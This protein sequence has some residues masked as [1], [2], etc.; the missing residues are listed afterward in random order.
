MVI[1][2]GVKT[3]SIGLV[4]LF[5]PNKLIKN[6]D[7]K[8]PLKQRGEGE[9]GDTPSS[10]DPQRSST[11]KPRLKQLRELAKASFSKEEIGVSEDPSSSQTNWSG[12][13][14]GKRSGSST[15][16][17]SSDS[18]TKPKG[19]YKDLEAIFASK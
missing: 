1:Y 8:F 15:M 7:S 18:K 11:E 13:W 6:L 14:T 10:G 19:L 5:L 9:T 3:A 17:L 2:F 4:L 12:F 16:S